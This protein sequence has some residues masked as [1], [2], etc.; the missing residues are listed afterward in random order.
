MSGIGSS[1]LSIL[2]LIGIAHNSSAIALRLFMPIQY[3]SRLLNTTYQSY[4]SITLI[5]AAAHA[6]YG[7]KK[8]IGLSP[9]ERTKTITLHLT[10]LAGYN[11]NAY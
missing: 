5:H 1:P 6:I 3:P 10:I 11:I 7:M 9:R 8:M 2:H 4:Y